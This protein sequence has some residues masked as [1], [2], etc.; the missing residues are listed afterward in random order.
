[1][2]QFR[3]VSISCT[4]GARLSSPVCAAHL[5]R[6]APVRQVRLWLR[7]DRHHPAVVRARLGAGGRRA[8]GGRGEPDQRHLRAGHPG[9][10]RER[11]CRAQ[12]A[13]PLPAHDDARMR[14][15]RTLLVST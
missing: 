10:G 4:A 5:P 1:M 7:H 11:R 2:H 15:Q 8:A 9:A 3:S 14:L 13:P 6:V 12:L